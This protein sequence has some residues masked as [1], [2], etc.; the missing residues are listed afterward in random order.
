MHDSLFTSFTADKC[1]DWLC[2]ACRSRS[3]AIL[4]GTF[5]RRENAFTIRYHH[6]ED[7][8]PQ[9]YAY[10]F[11]CLLKCHNPTCGE[12]VAVS[13]TGGDEFDGGYDEHGNPGPRFTEFFEAKHFY[14]PLPLFVPPA[15]CPDRVAEQLKEVSSLLTGHFSSAANAIRSLVEMLLDDLEVPR[16]LDRP[17]KAPRPLWLNE[18][19]TRYEDII[20]D[21]HA[22]MDALKLFGNAGSHGSSAITR[23]HLE[24]ACAIVEQLI[25]ELYPRKADASTQIVRLKEA[26]SRKPISDE[27]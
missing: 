3:L 15:A 12:A 25:I 14:P 26:F 4:P 10:V 1:P 19:L 8:R 2:P 13:G 20:G 23:Q 5:H 6:H 22:G 16:T 17:G 9:D 27:N 24:D 18:R 11:S 21:H 7:F